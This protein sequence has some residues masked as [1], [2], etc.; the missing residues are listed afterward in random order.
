MLLMKQ[1]NVMT[2]N[3]PGVLADITNILGKNGVNILTL[4][5]ET[6]SDSAIIR[7][8]TKDATSTKM[9]LSQNGYRVS[10]SEILCF[11]IMDRP[12]ELAKVAN[13]IYD[14]GINIENIYLLTRKGDKVQLAIRFNDNDTVRKR[15]GNYIVEI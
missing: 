15:F 13:R 14:E 8:I 5:A 9:L 4:T 3:K 11:E 2:E 6:F 7:I 12:G 10:D 1:I